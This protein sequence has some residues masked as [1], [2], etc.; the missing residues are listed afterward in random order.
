WREAEDG[1]LWMLRSEG[2]VASEIASRGAA[3]QVG[4]RPGDLLLAIDG[5]PVQQVDDVVRALHAGRPGTTLR[6]T[7]LRLDTRDIVNVQLAAV[8]NGNA[9]LYFFLAGVGIF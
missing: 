2:V 3:D 1:V 8:P 5:R 4:V 7:I 9:P 6:Y